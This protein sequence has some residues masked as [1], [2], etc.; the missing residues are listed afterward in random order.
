MKTPQT[1]GLFKY[2]ISCQSDI[3]TSGHHYRWQQGTRPKWPNLQHATM[4]P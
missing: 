1:V 3:I 4:T 2:L